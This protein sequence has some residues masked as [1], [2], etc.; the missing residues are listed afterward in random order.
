ELADLAGRG[1]HVR[2][3]AAVADVAVTRLRGE[4][5]VDDVVGERHCRSHGLEED[6]VPHPASLASVAEAVAVHRIRD[7]PAHRADAGAAARGLA[8]AR[9]AG[10]VVLAD[11]RFACAGGTAVLA[12]AAGGDAAAEA[13]DA[14]AAVALVVEAAAVAE[15]LET[16]AAVAR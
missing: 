6:E 15:R 5:I 8:V 7:N 1:K 3:S 9:H 2:G 11:D 13:V 12:L 4:A 16:A 10:V 14:V